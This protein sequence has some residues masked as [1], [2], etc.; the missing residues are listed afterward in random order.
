M[1]DI[2]ISICKLF[3]FLD[4]HATNFVKSCSCTIFKEKKN[5]EQIIAFIS[6]NMEKEKLMRYHNFRTLAIFLIFHILQF[7]SY[8]KYFYEY[9]FFFFGSLLHFR[10]KNLVFDIYE[11]IF[12]IISLKTNVP[13]NSM[14][15]V[16][17]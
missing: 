4:I 3:F 9:K 2:Y 15:N 13:L 12:C 10:Q 1:C 5:L 8:I 14:I 17:T 6:E 16:H 7:F 11:K